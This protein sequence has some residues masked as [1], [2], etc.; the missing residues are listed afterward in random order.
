MS[1]EKLFL[2]KQKVENVKDVMHENID[3]ALKNCIKLET[4][5]LKAEE[6]EQ[7]ASIFKRHTT[8]LR[9]K[10]WWKNMKMKLCFAFIILIIIAIIVGIIVA[11]THK[12]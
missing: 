9:K 3:V 7:Q 12:K 11:Y 6:M 5:E 1:N 4:I 8:E 10:M 2:V